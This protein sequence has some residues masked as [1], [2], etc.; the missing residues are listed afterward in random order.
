[1][2]TLYIA[3]FVLETINGVPY[4][5]QPPVGEQ[6][7]A[8]AAGAASSAPFSHAT[9]LVRLH[10]DVACSIRF[11]GGAASSANTRMAA[12]QTE[13]F[14]APVPGDSVSVIASA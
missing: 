5:K 11:G 14:A 3:E 12:N 7:V 1:M 6:T 4:A 9:K 2:A 13:Y 8:I 10:C